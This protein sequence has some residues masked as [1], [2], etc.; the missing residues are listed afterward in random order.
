ML[1]YKNRSMI[2]RLKK[3]L[4]IYDKNSLVDIFLLALKKINIIKFSSFIE[5]EKININ[6]KIINITKFKIIYGPYKNTI[7]YQK[8]YFDNSGNKLLGFYESQIQ[9]KIIELKKKFNLDF[10]INFGCGDGFHVLGLIKKKIFKK[11]LVYDINPDSKKILNKN[12]KLNNI[13]SR[14]EVFDEANFNYLKN[15]Q[16]KINYKK[17]LFLIDIEGLEFNLLNTQNLKY[18]KNSCLIIENHDFFISKKKDIKK[19]WKL[20]KS[21]YSI[22]IVNNSFRNPFV[23]NKIDNFNDDERWLTMSEGRLCNQNWIVCIP[24]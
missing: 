3:I 18:F 7:Y 1:D 23:I 21:N 12:L 16:D 6:K 10:L 17:I 24:K 5:R 4:K 20:L 8:P 11:G 14:V 13:K 2:N 9:Q 19:F 15:N 22:E